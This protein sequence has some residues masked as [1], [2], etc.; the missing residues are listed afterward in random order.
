[1]EVMC[2]ASYKVFE[3]KLIL[4]SKRKNMKN[5]VNIFVL[6]RTHKIYDTLLSTYRYVST[7]YVNLV[8]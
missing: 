1:M 3:G 5:D 7:F 4:C 6:F 2:E 8:T